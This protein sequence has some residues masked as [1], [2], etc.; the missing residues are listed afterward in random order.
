MSTFTR[1]KCYRVAPDGTVTTLY[2][3]DGPDLGPQEIQRASHVEPGKD[4]GWD[5]VLTDHP[6]NGKWKGH[7]VARGV[8]RRQD[9]LRLEIDFINEHC[10]GEKSDA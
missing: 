2:S 7:V 10:L 1:R 5:V 3:D 8:K 6:R 9:A 4:G